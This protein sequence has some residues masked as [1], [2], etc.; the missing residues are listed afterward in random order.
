MSSR[1]SPATIGAFVVSGVVLVVAAVVLFGSGRVFDERREFVAFFPGSVN[2]LAVGSNVAFRGVRVGAVKEIRLAMGSTGVS[3][4]E[5][6]RIPVIFEIDETTIEQRGSALDL[7]DPAQVQMLID[8]G[9]AARLDTESMLTGRLFISLDFRP[10]ES[11]VLYGVQHELVEVP[12][13]PS[14]MA[15][16][17]AK[18]QEVANKLLEVDVD[19]VMTSMRQTL[20]GLNGLINDEDM[21]QMPG[22]VDRMMATLETTLLAFQDL[23]VTVDSTVGPMR[24][25]LTDAAIQAETSMVEV[26]ST[27]QSMRQMMEPTAPLVVNMGRALEEL[28]LAA[29]SLRRVAEMIERDPTVLVRGRDTRG[30]GS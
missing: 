8:Q 13:V 15:L 14:P 28:E 26:E 1:V 25:T 7:G 18:L 16:A 21:Q 24:E 6:M 11:P 10:G 19:A 27:L 17:T 29:R 3:V 22:D 12:T 9:L 4:G 23:A 2:G 5:S 20:E 30:G